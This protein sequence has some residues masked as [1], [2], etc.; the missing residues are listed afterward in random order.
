MNLGVVNAFQEEYYKALEY[1]S[2]ADS[3]I[4]LH[5]VEDMK[6]FILLNL[7]DVYNRLNRSDSAYLYF[8]KSLDE[9]QKL[10]DIDLIGTSQTGLGHSYLKLENYPQSLISYQNAITNLKIANDDEILA[11]LCL[12][13]PTYTS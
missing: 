10:N 1:Y 7:G 2:L 13:L 9:A 11:K 3:V 8:M 5:H 6:Y 4:R 12:G